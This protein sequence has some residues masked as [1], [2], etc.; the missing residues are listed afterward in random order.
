LTALLKNKNTEIIISSGK[1]EQLI[2]QLN[3]AKNG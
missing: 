1:N 3:F 2:D